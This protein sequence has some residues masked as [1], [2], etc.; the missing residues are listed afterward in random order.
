MR[1]TPIILLM[2][3]SLGIHRGS[4]FWSSRGTALAAIALMH[5]G[6]L[7]LA[8]QHRL[9]PVEPEAGLVAISLLAPAPRR[10][11][12]APTQTAPRLETPVQAELPPPELDWKSSEEPPVN[13]ITAI[14]PPPLAQAMPSPAPADAGAPLQISVA[15]YLRAPVP[16][17]PPAA[18]SARREGSVGLR[19]VVGTDGRVIDV[20]VEQSS[21][22]GPF[23]EAACSAVR[24]AL[25]KPYTVNG[26]PR[27]VLVRIPIDFTLRRRGV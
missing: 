8:L 15:Q 23:D 6:L 20:R 5:G 1:E 2:Q 22:F 24:A 18:L 12:P 4:R 11:R 16:R 17:Y 13:T 7:A 27:V 19:V 26:E 10:E 21:G 9:N 25:F 3:G 14:R